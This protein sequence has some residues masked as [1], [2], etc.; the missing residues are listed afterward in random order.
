MKK[1]LHLTFEQGRGRKGGGGVKWEGGGIK[2]EVVVG[3]KAPLS[4]VRV[5]EGC[6]GVKWVVVG[7]KAPP[8]RVQVREG[9]QVEIKPLR[10]AFQVREGWWWPKNATQGWWVSNEGGGG[11]KRCAMR[12]CSSLHCHV[13]AI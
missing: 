6:G 10:L 13:P 1:P 2:R 8:A 3:S 7:S 5:R 12:M 9:C 4:L 11:Q